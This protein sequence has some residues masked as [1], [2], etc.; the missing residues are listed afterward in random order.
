MRRDN[1]CYSSP[2]YPTKSSLD[3]FAGATDRILGAALFCAVGI[4]AIVVLIFV[5]RRAHALRSRR[6]R[7]KFVRKLRLLP[8]RHLLHVQFSCD[9]VKA[10][11][12]QNRDC[13]HCCKRDSSP[14]RLILRQ[15]AT[16]SLERVAWDRCNP[17]V[18]SMQDSPHP[19]SVMS[20]TA[21]VP[22]IG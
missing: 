21:T 16:G 9:R 13:E 15:R 6:N 14:A 3:P 7:P 10:L 18:G 1:R 20:V 4:T 2:L 22:S 5:R 11:G 8:A 17:P 19:S 12:G